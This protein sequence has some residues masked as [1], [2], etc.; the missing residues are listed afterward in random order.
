MFMLFKRRIGGRY[1]CVVVMSK[2][3]PIR[4]CI[5]VDAF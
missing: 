1:L 3:V 5:C 2:V 4:A